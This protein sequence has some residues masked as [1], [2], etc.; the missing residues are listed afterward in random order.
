MAVSLWCYMVDFQ[1]GDREHAAGLNG[2]IESSASFVII[3][4]LAFSGTLE[5]CKVTSVMELHRVSGFEPPAESTVKVE[6]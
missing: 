5:S 1:S 3:V 2:C 4:T 6:G